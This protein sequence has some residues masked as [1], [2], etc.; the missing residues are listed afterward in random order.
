MHT[1]RNILSLF[2]ICNFQVKPAT[3][4]LYPL[5]CPAGYDLVSAGQQQGGLE[6]QCDKNNKL[7]I[8]CEDDQDTLI[9]EVWYN[10]RSELAYSLTPYTS[11]ETSAEYVAL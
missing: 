2:Y 4:T 8:N 11:V 10:T 9:V 7:I 6:C 1:H 3:F 5:P